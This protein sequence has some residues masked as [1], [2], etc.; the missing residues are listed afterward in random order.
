[1]LWLVLPLIAGLT[2]GRLGEFAPAGWQL[3]LALVCAVAALVASQRHARAWA[4]ALIAAMFFAGSASYAL[5]RARLAA[6]DA[7]PPREA[8]LALRIE[9]VFPQTD[10][11]KTGGLARIVRADEHL[12]E[13]TGQRVYFSLTARAGEPAPLRSAIVAVVGVLAPLPRDPP[14]DSFDGY[15]AAAGANFRLTRGRVTALEQPPTRYQAFLARAAE[16]LNALLG[17]GIA[18]KR[19]DLAA[20]FR[21][22]MLGQKHELSEA[23][24]ELFLHSGTMHLFAING[25]HIGVVALSLHAL[26]AALRC[27]RPAAA[28]VTLAV[29]WLDVDTTGASPSAVRAFLLVAFYEAAFVLRRPANG[30]AALSAAALAVLL[31][32]PLALFSASFQMSYGVVLAILGFGLPLVERIQQTWSPFRDQPA[33][34]WTW[35]QR[36]WAAALRWFWPV[37]GIGLAATLVSALTGPAFFGV[38]AAGGLFANLLIVPLAMFVIVAGFASILAGLAGLASVGVLFNHAALVLLVAIDALIRRGVQLPAV[39]HAATWRAAWAAP[40]ALVALLAVVLAGYATGWR[41][42]RGS[43]WPPFA[44]VAVALVFGV[45]F[46]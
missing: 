31:L 5:H 45:K 7:L 24:D 15:L 33:A 34:T 28:L 46:G 30:L 4:A 10:P 43:W 32:E 44:V 35:W 8:R 40:L 16:K 9:R 1:M 2:A 14:A 41:R 27:P 37:L 29:L 38:F 23:Q 42:N 6:W 21:A 25:L 13:L 19:P 20:V 11:K 18:S 36:A 26:L 3:A 22:M 39:W 17:A 12:R